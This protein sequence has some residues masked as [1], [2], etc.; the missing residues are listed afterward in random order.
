MSKRSSII[1]SPN[2]ILMSMALMESI[3]TQSPLPYYH[4]KHKEDESDVPFSNDDCD[5]S[6]NSYDSF[7]LMQSDHLH[8]TD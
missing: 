7:Q 8:D 6:L 2:P 5:S 4:I 1:S 3:S